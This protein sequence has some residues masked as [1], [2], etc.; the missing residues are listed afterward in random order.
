[1]RLNREKLKTPGNE[2]WIKL[3]LLE[4]ASTELSRN[5]DLTLSLEHE[6]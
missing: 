5:N 4:T 6:T 2:T 3:S 1:M